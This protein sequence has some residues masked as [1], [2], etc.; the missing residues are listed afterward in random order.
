MQSS[1]QNF[2]CVLQ[3]AIM[4]VE[5]WGEASQEDG[6]GMLTVIILTLKVGPFMLRKLLLFTPAC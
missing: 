1:H 2:G 6:D 4:G 3:V 5:V